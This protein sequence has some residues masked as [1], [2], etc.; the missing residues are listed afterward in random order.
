MVLACSCSTINNSSSV[1]EEDKLYVTRTYLGNYLSFMHTNPDRYGNPDLIWIST[2]LDS[3]NGRISAYSEECHF[4]PGERLYLRRVLATVGKAQVWVYQVENS[5]TVTY[6]INEYQVHNTVPLEAWFDQGDGEEELPLS[7][8]SGDA[9][10]R[11]LAENS[12][13]ASTSNK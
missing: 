8:P 2:T 5:D 1:I 3:I 13:S 6:K 4:V 9:L 10:N 7:L 12:V 11:T